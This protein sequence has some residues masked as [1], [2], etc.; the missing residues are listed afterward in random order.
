MISRRRSAILIRCGVA[1]IAMTTGSQIC[2]AQADLNI[3]SR[4]EAATPSI[5]ETLPPATVRT[6]TIDSIEPRTVVRR[7]QVPREPREIAADVAAK[8]GAS[9][10]TFTAMQ[11]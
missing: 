6:I 5:R 7:R 10:A 4:I 1:A 9:I 2:L 3:Q 8:K 11:T